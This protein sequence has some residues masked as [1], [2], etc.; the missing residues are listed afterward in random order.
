MPVFSGTTLIYLI[1]AGITAAIK[2]QQTGESGLLHDIADA[3]FS[4]I[5]GDAAAKG[6]NRAGSYADFLLE[7]SELDHRSF[8]HDLAR[9]AKRSMMQ[10]TAIAARGCVSELE[11]EDKKSDKVIWLTRLAKSLEVQAQNLDKT[12][13]QSYL[14][15]DEIM[16]VFG[17]MDKNSLEQHLIA[18]L[19]EEAFELIREN[20]ET[21]AIFSRDGFEYLKK[22][23]Q[24]HWKEQK[25]PTA[26][27]HI[28]SWYQLVSTAFNEEYKNNLQV[29]AAIAKQQSEAVLKILGRLSEHF[30]NIASN[31]QSIKETTDRIESKFD[32]VLK[33]FEIPVEIPQME[34]AYHE[35][36]KIP[37]YNTA[38]LDGY[39]AHLHSLEKEFESL[40]ENESLKR[41]V[42]SQKITV[43]TRLIKEYFNRAADIGKTLK[44]VDLRDLSNVD[45][46]RLEKVKI[47]FEAGKILK[48][49]QELEN[50]LERIDDERDTLLK[51]KEEW[52]KEEAAF[53]E[54]KKDYE[55]NLEPKLR[56]KS[57]EY[58][59]L[60][61]G[62]QIDFGN[63]GR[64]AD[65]SRYFEDSIRIFETSE[66]LSGFAAFLQQQNKFAD[67]TQLYER[68]LTEFLSELSEANIAAITNNLAILHAETGKFEDAEKRFTQALG[69]R[70][71]LAKAKPNIYLPN[72]ANL[73]NNLGLLHANTGKIENAE[74]EYN[75][76]LGIY[77]KLAE[78]N[79]DD[80]LSHIALTF[81]N[82]AILY[83]K[84]E[85]LEDADKEFNKA[86]G[87][88][89]KLAEANPDAY[90]PEVA[91]TL[92]NLANVYADTRKLKNA[93]KE[94]NEAL[95]IR[96]KLAEANPDAYLPYVAT[97]AAN[98]AVFYQESI[99]DR[100]RSIH[101]AIDAI[102]AAW[103]FAEMLVLCQQIIGL[104]ISVLRNWGLSDEE[105]DKLVTDE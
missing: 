23:I 94:Y 55:E 77:N 72:I 4:G 56:T 81:N 58:L 105:I 78:A 29:Q 43:H 69:I 15:R 49:Y 41:I 33:I 21:L 7:V 75:E 31:V 51:H 30:D 17:G 37:G 28:V 64:L 24:T 91:M 60:A 10:A 54:K 12:T 66:N 84:T 92:N 80:Y 79:P 39:I 103:P 87:I 42:C 44:S 88:Y 1:G 102:R 9:A 16:G 68:I 48:A 86:L 96:R 59:I 65:T 32:Q 25:S 74:K 40:P 93:E 27:E 35:L 97:T 63:P 89:N 82:L 34:W 46:S 52:G 104:A 61:Q 26:P 6:L 22:A 13:P 90:L 99:L 45:V 57:F 83:A 70:R 50:D 3:G 20:E 14:T 11:Y 38:E 36:K 85:K 5:I 101:L 71:K 76:A 100:D 62:A 2:A 53:T 73:L 18:K 8:N 95:R 98:L 47:L 19:H 67:S